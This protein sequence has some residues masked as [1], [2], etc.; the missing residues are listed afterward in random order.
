MQRWLEQSLNTEVTWIAAPIKEFLQFKQQ[1][2]RVMDVV[3][4]L[5][6]NGADI[7]S[8]SDTGECPIYIAALQGRVVLF[9]PL[10]SL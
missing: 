7:N 5:L 10:S 1:L 3:V 6:E 2:K 4:A 9:K 8:A